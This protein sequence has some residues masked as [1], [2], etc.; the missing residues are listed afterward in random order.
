[1]ASKTSLQDM[2]GQCSNRDARVWLGLQRVWQRQTVC[3]VAAKMWVNTVNVL[4]R[5]VYKMYNNSSKK[6]GRLLDT[7][8][9]FVI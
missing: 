8:M 4:R 6:R 7:Q 3:I 2:V 1:M 9:S 5:V